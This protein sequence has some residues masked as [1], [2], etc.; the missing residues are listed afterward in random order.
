[1]GEEGSW[2]QTIQEW[3]IDEGHCYAGALANKE[4]GQMYAAAPV[5]DQEGWTY[6]FKDCHEEEVMQD[7]MSTTKVI[8]DETKALLSVATTFKAPPSGLWMGGEKYTVTRVSDIEAGDTTLKVIFCNKP[9][10]GVVIIP[11]NTQIIIAMYSEEKGQE[12]RMANKTA[13]A[14]AEYMVGA[15]Y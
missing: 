11:T 14:F 2:D 9:K 13:L 1:M 4:D 8:I 12:G 6:V 7:D 3:L 5:A 15:G 10:K